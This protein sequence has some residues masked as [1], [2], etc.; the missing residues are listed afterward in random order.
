VQAIG[1][2]QEGRKLQACARSMDIRSL[3]GK[4]ST[5]GKEATGIS[6]LFF[7]RSS[8]FKKKEGG[9]NHRMFVI[10]KGNYSSKTV[11]GKGLGM[12]KKI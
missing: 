2:K 10:E 7:A 1:I 8:D 3:E 5:D 6:G 9:K 11:A 12:M 4:A